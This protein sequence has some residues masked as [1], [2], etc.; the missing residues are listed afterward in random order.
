MKQN[1]TNIENDISFVL[2]LSNI[3]SA[4]NKKKNTEGLVGT[5]KTIIEYLEKIY[6]ITTKEV[7]I[8]GN[9]EDYI[10]IQRILSD[11]PLIYLSK[12]ISEVSYYFSYI[13]KL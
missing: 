12:E 3:I 7:S 6:Q 9:Q 5:E 10:S 13:L 1:V 11:D 8:I 4:Y 2:I